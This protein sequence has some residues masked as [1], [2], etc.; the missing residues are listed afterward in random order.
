M[1]LKSLFFAAAMALALPAAIAPAAHAQQGRSFPLIA[2][3]RAYA[4]EVARMIDDDDLGSAARSVIGNLRSTNDPATF[5][6]QMTAMT[7]RGPVRYGA[8]ASD[9][10]QE[11]VGRMIC[12]YRM[13]E[14][15]EAAGFF[16]YVFVF[17]RSDRGWHLA[18]FHYNEVGNVLVAPGC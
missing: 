16:F 7:N 2:D 18:N 11:G 4:D 8:V 15:A 9:R 10:T 5:A 1:S 13:R 14:S 12:L 17:R 6:Q 3:P